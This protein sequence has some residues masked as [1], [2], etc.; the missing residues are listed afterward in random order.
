METNARY[1][2]N[3]L[4]SKGW[5]LNA[6]AGILGNMQYESSIS[7]GRGEIGGSGFGL[8]QWT[9]K[10]NLTNWTSARGYADN[11]FDGQ[12]EKIINEKDTG[13][14]YIKRNYKYTFKE[15][16]TSVDNPYTLA[17]AFAFD[18]ERSWVTLYGTESEKEILRKKRGSA[19]EE[20][21]NFLAPYAPNT[22]P[23]EKFTLDG[24]KINL[25]KPTEITASFIVR[26]G[27]SGYYS[28]FDHTGKEIL[29]EQL[30]IT[31]SKSAAEV[32]S[33]KCN[34]KIIPNANYTLKVQ[35]TGSVGE[36]TITRSITFTTPQDYPTKVKS[37]T[38]SCVDNIKSINSI[39][40]LNIE[41]PSALGYWSK[42]GSG[43]EKILIVNGKSVKTKT[44]N[45]IKNKITEKFTIKNEFDYDC[46][47]GDTIQVGI[48]IWV[49][50]DNGNIIYDS[51]GISASNTICLLNS[52]VRAYLNID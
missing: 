30:S 26:N 16:S 42:N 27:N 47:T 38:L 24:L 28:L 29:K 51:S 17:C 31:S 11:D 48:R 8:V 33:F 2:W 43:Y 18:Y 3:Y 1:I 19:A 14:Q 6:V 5:S 39:F 34:N 37:I 35:A 12:L 36:N 22:A 25:L 20:W 7:P 32:I 46:K 52:Q 9:P 50:D 45:R 10:T 44:I 49:R 41:I 13:G 4:G 40:E 15:F 21:Y 23:A